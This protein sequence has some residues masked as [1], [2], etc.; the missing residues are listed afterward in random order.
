M[1][2]PVAQLALNMNQY[3]NDAVGSLGVYI[4]DLQIALEGH[5][6]LYSW[7]LP[8]ITGSYTNLWQGFYTH[9]YYLS[10]NNS[11]YVLFLLNLS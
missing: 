3:M 9:I 6:E 10:E 2:E 4:Q 11:F 1:T 5:N 7:Q 8:Y